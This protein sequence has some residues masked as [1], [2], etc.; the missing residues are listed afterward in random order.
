[1]TDR[2]K[3]VS[4]LNAHTNAQAGD[5]LMVVSQPGQVGVETKKITLGNLFANVS[6]NAVFTGSKFVIPSTTPPVSA[7]STGT[8]GE[9]RFDSDYLYVCVSNNTWVRSNLS[10]W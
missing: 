9:I 7:S 3:K 4:E 2:A 10:T 1:M 8:T 6:S 5:L